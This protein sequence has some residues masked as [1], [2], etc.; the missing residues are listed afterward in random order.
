MAANDLITLP[1]FKAYLNITSDADDPLLAL[2]IGSAS[3]YLLGQMNRQK[4][5]M[6]DYEHTKGLAE[7]PEDLRF[8]CM[9]LAALRYAEKSRLGEVSKTIGQQTVAFSQKDLSDFARSV[10]NQYKRVTP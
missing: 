3:R 1:E 7:V 6:H 9:E 4:G 10:V 5:L 8:A 2:L